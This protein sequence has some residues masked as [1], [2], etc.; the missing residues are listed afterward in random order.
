MQPEVECQ[1]CPG[2]KFAGDD[3]WRRAAHL[4]LVLDHLQRGI[5]EDERRDI[6]AVLRAPT[7]DP[8]TQTTGGDVMMQ[9]TPS[10]GLLIGAYGLHISLDPGYQAVPQ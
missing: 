7:A 6:Q 4:V 3:M 9:T 2:T 8:G 5:T 10:G 1:H